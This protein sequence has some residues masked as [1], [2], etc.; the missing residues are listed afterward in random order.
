MILNCRIP[1][2]VVLIGALLA[3]TARSATND[4]VYLMGD[5]DSP[6]PVNDGNVITTFDSQGQPSMSQFVDLLASPT[7]P[8][9]RTITGRPDGVG[10]FGVEFTGTQ[11]LR[12][13]ALG[14][15]STSFSALGGTHPGTL[16]YN[17]LVDRGMQFWVRPAS[18]AT[19]SLVMDTNQ[20]GVRIS[21]GFFAMRYNNTD[22][23]T[24]KAV[25]ANTWYHVMLV[26]PSGTTFG[27]QLYI[28]GEAAAVSLG[29]YDQTDTAPLV[30]GANTAGTDTA[31][32]GGTTEFFSGIVDDL[33]LF[34]IGNNSSNL[35]PPVGQNWGDFD[36]FTD[37][38]YV[39]WA[40]TGVLGDVDNDGDLDQDDKDDFIAGWMT[41][42]VVGGLQL[43]DLASLK[44]GD[45]N[46]DGAT[47]ISDLAIMQNALAGGGLSAI[48]AQDLA[49]VPE[50]AA[51]VLFILGAGLH[52]RRRRK[53]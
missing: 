2:S 24:T 12:N 43:A 48:T 21:S 50:P 31:F 30:V 53:R 49:G 40:Y 18:T 9:Y 26:R 11:Y 17:T 29:G 46:L 10:G 3:Q 19:Q 28:N 13:Y 37:N 15:P 27:S 35:G 47:N 38:D 8:K 22:F 51:G 34:V 44:K 1:L 4:R 6:V 42:N 41:K 33:K 14:N 25:T 36:L 23:V 45:L 52:C 39:S 32:G 7:R 20:H 16:N 5:G